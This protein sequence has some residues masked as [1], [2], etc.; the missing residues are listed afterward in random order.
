MSGE[1]LLTLEERLE[2]DEK[3]LIAI[4]T[5]LPQLEELL[6]VFQS[7]YEDRMYRLYYQSFKVYELQYS[8]AN[9]AALFKTIGDDIGRDLCA[10]F[11]EIVQAGTCGEFKTDHNTDWL[12]HTRPIVEAFLHAKYFLE[13]MIKYGREFDHA[14]N[15]FLPTG[16]AAI[17]VL[18]NQR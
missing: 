9:A 2:R 14:P 5:H 15:Q 8:T 18:Y 12:R 11:Q 7:D 4:R 6:F 16:W 10:W 17:L 13:M 1:R 3:L